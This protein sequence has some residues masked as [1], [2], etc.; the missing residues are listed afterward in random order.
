MASVSKDKR[1]LLKDL[2]LDMEISLRDKYLTRGLNKGDIFATRILELDGHH[3]MGGCVYPYI[4]DHKKKVLAAVDK[5]FRRY[6]KN[7][8]PEGTMHAYLKDYGD[9]FNLVWMKFITEPPEE[10]E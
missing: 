1:V 3:V 8:N 6:R 9:V 5:Q 2:L 10:K 7:V 4:S